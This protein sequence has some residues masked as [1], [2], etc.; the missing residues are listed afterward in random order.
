MKKNLREPSR[1][2]RQNI[3]ILLV[4]DDPTSLSAMEL[5]LRRREFQISRV[6]DRKKAVKVLENNIFDL[7]I[8]DLMLPKLNDGL[9][10]IRKAKEQ[11]YRPAVLGITG[12]ETVENAV[13]VMK[14]G[15]DDFIGK[16]FSK[17]ELSIR[18][19]KMLKERKR[20]ESLIIET[21]I[22]KERLQKEFGSYK[23][24]G[25][26]K[27]IEL[28][29][30]TIEKVARD[31]QSNC[32]IQ[33]ETGTGKELVARNLHLKSPR[34]NHPFIPLNCASIPK[35]LMESELFGYEK[36]SFT[37]ATERR[38]GKFELANKGILFFDEI[39]DLHVD[40]Q[41]K[42]LR[43]MEDKEFF[44]IGGSKPV[45]VDVQILSATNR[46]L[47]DEVEKGN[48]RED[49]FYRLSVVTINIPPFRER[50]EDIIPV[51][52]HLLR[53]L[54]SDRGREITL[55][56]SAIN[57]LKKYSYP[58]N[59]RELRNVLERAIILSEKNIIQASDLPSEMFH[60]EVCETLNLNECLYKYERTLLLDALKRNNWVKTRAAKELG[61]DH[62]LLH[63]KMERLRINKGEGER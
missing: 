51:A 17:G 58:G 59:G 32:L 56:P 53:Q 4:D 44:R 35:D 1:S 33:G 6:Q 15:A 40:L 9:R 16:G 24:I 39:S 46:N 2:S 45:K 26:S 12:Y 10:V 19:D 42:L 23:I 61:I 25:K 38:K 14:A 20:S 55:D 57:V 7:V 62:A 30:K 27:A 54:G 11:A 36:G 41:A 5:E 18:V 21:T 52:N 13:E 37:G 34:R 29:K 8:C 63:R 60:E 47:K 50:V 31:A 22:L 43:A 3:N 48:F 28:I 49:L